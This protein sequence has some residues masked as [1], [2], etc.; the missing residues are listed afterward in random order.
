M[1]DRLDPEDALEPLTIRIEECP[2]GRTV[3]SLRGEFD[4]SA[5]RAFSRAIAEALRSSPRSLVVDLGGVSFM[6]STGLRSLV[7]AQEM[8]VGRGC[9]LALRR[10]NDP[11]RRPLELARLIDLFEIEDGG[12]A[13]EP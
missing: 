8:A 12:G 5:E 11:V 13:I 7:I 6:D 3:L 2:G 9:R 4:L 1:M 10:A